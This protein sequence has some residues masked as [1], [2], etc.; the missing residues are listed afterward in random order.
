M[1]IKRII[2][3]YYEQLYAHKCDNL[4]EMDQFLE[5][6]NLPKLTQEE[7]DDLNQPMSIKEMESI[8]NNL[9][10]QK[11]PGPDVVTGEYH[12]TFKEEMIRILYNFFQRIETE[13]ILLSSFYEASIVPISNP[14]IDITRKEN[15]R[16]RSLMNIDAKVLN[17]N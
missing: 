13:R 5:R 15:Y 11:T 3:E 6:Q 4:D 9:P 2:K 17:K 8:I 16:L 7:I 12:Q 1:E 10:K 14:D